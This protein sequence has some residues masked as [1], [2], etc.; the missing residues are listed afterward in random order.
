MVPLSYLQM[1]RTEIRSI[2]ILPFA[3]EIVLGLASMNALR[4]FLR[5]DNHNFGETIT[6]FSAW[7]ATPKRPRPP[8]KTPNWELLQHLRQGLGW[9]EPQ[10]FLQRGLVTAQCECP[11]WFS[12]TSRLCAFWVER[13]LYTFWANYMLPDPR[14]LKWCYFST[15]KVVGQ[16]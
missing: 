6:L 4:W 7:M 2:W 11:R 15:Y 16:R 13:R 9:M 8:L 12:H 14:I 1:G 3:L 5:G 10:N